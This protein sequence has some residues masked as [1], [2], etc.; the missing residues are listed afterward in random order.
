MPDEEIEGA[1]LPKGILVDETSAYFGIT[2]SSNLLMELEKIDRISAMN[3]VLKKLGR[4]LLAENF[5]LD[6]LVE[7]L[8]V[9]G[10]EI[11]YLLSGTFGLMEIVSP[12]QSFLDSNMNSIPDDD[13]KKLQLL[14]DPLNI[15]KIISIGYINGQDQE[16][17]GYSEKLWEL[18]GNP[19]QN[20]LPLLSIAKQ[21][22]NI[23][24]LKESDDVPSITELT[25]GPSTTHS[26]TIRDDT[27]TENT[28]VET[29]NIQENENNTIIQDDLSKT[30]VFLGSEV[31]E[32]PEF[33]R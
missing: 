27:S 5:D 1:A 13:F 10:G 26:T 24:L 7:L 22:S 17:A 28:Y 30:E 12:L 9:E 14:T 21:L 33:G 2:Q 32:Y 19:S 16:V 23:F 20:L 31:I 25:G 29:N 15:L 6:T 18:L 4:N 11:Y 8:N 3:I